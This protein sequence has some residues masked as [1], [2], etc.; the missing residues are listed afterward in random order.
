[1]VRPADN[2]MNSP[3][4]KLGHEKVVIG[5]HFISDLR[6]QGY[7]VTG[8]AE[9]VYDLADPDRVG[10]VD[11]ADLFHKLKTSQVGELPMH[12]LA[13][14]GPLTQNGC[15]KVSHQLLTC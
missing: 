11:Q 15:C 6:S 7:S 5:L 10:C 14:G 13:R 1:M 9:Q 8:I 2:S 4:L 3:R 12:P